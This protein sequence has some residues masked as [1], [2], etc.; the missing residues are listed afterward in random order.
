[1]FHRT[2]YWISA[3]ILS[4]SIANAQTVTGAD[5]VQIATAIAAGDSISFSSM[6]TEALRYYATC[7]A[8][9][10]SGKTGFNIVSKAFSLDGSFDEQK[11]KEY[12]SKQRETYSIS[13]AVYTKNKVVFD[14]ALTT[15]EAC[16]KATQNRGWNIV[17]TPLHKNSVSITL[18]NTAA[19]GGDLINIDLLPPN[20]ISCRDMPRSFPQTVGPSPVSILCTRPEETQYISGIAYYSAQDVTIN[21]RLDDS[22]IP[23]RLAG[24]TDSA[25]NAA[26]SDIKRLDNG[27]SDTRTLL[28]AIDKRVSFLGGGAATPRG[29]VGG[30]GK[31]IFWDVAACPPGE[32]V[33]G[34]GFWGA[35]GQSSCNGCFHGAQ[36]VCKPFRQ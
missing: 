12:C 10:R 36:V 20:V 19:K 30:A 4:G 7:E 28:D 26:L 27:L 13:S 22:Q 35:S 33:A 14:R 21:L 29:G 18:F 31:G 1:M 15:V 25:L 24:Y 3:L 2:A 16:L 9:S 5:C 34:V 17:Y 8:S 32:Y 11:T 23:I 6:D